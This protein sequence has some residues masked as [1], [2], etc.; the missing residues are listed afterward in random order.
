M[1]VPRDELGRQ[2]QRGR[3]AAPD[4]GR[5]PAPPATPAHQLA[6]KLKALTA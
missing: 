4:P 2:G 6:S 5:G 3:G 1:F